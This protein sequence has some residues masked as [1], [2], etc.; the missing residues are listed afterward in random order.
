LI[1][2]YVEDLVTAILTAID[3]PKARQ[4]TFNICM[5]EPVDYGKAALYLAEN[6]SC[7]ALR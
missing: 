7:Q 1:C 4:Q 5:D 6:I 2:D 3:N